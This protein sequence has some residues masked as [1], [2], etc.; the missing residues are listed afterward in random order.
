VSFFVVLLSLDFIFLKNI[1]GSYSALIVKKSNC[2][3]AEDTCPV[4]VSLQAGPPS[5]VDATEPAKKFKAEHTRTPN[6]IHASQPHW[7]GIA[8][9]AT[10]LS[11][12]KPRLHAPRQ[13][14]SSPAGSAGPH[15]RP[16]DPRR[17]LVSAPARRPTR[18]RPIA[19]PRTRSRSALSSLDSNQSTALTDGIARPI[20]LLA[21]L[22][23]RFSQPR[24]A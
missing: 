5:A 13:Q 11:T 3:A 21:P 4:E 8:I 24:L 7:L 1:I 9:R 6:T 15:H 17:R 22:R 2:C 16:V 14:K 10:P 18:G 23:S 20:N 19:H 12:V